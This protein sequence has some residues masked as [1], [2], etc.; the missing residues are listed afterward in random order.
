MMTRLVFGKK[1]PDLGFDV[2]APTATRTWDLL[3]RRRWQAQARA[4]VT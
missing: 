1:L 4:A 3:L 2:C